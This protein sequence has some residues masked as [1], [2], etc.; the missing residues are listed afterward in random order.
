[1][2]ILIIERTDKKHMY[3]SDLSEIHSLKIESINT[4]TLDLYIPLHLY[5]IKKSVFFS[6]VHHKRH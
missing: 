5:T 3:G 1:M 6:L 2:S 4:H